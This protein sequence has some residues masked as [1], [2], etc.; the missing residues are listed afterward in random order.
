MVVP[1]QFDFEKEDASIRMFHLNIVQNPNHVNL[2]YVKYR[3]PDKH[4]SHFVILFEQPLNDYVSV[5]P[6]IFEGFWK[7][8]VLKA[9]IVFWSTD[10]SV[11]TYTPFG[12]EYLVSIPIENTSLMDLF[13]DKARDMNGHPLKVSLFFEETRAIFNRNFHNDQLDSITGTDGLLT[14]LMIRRMNATL[15]LI[16]PNDGADIGEFMKNGNIT[17]SMGQIANSMVD[18]SFNTRFLRIVQFKRKVEPT[19]TNGRDDICILVPKAGFASSVSNLFRSFSPPLWISTILAVPIFIFIYKLFCI[20]SKEKA[21]VSWNDIVFNVIAWNLLQTNSKLP[22]R[23]VVR[24]LI[25]TW[26]MYTL[27]ITSSY[28]GNLTSNLLFRRMMPDINTIKQLDQSNYQL[29]TFDRYT[30]LINN[31]LN[32]TNYKRLKKRIKP[33]TQQEFYE[34]ID[35]NDTRYAYANKYHINFKLY[36]TRLNGGRQIFHNMPECPVPYVVIYGMRYGSPY[37]Q[38]INYILRQAQEAGFI[39]YWDNKDKKKISGKRSLQSGGSEALVPL[40]I[41]HLQSAFFI[42]FIGLAL[43]IVYFFYETFGKRLGTQ[44]ISLPCFMNW[45]EMKMSQNLFAYRAN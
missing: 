21:I 14:Q 22:K 4:R 10:L 7:R 40:S 44:K 37:K 27:L 36:N 16:Q 28:G 2:S 20:G 1:G 3:F 24:I 43:S 5:L 19:V 23:W 34:M 12:E 32:Q 13:P 8:E 35:K 39:D 6:K 18:V 42:Y 38:R 31:F 26:A 41:L 33:M 25:G 17:G 30:D 29:I 11:I 45:G 15:V 9:L